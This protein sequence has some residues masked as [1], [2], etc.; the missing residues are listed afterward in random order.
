MVTVF[1]SDSNADSAPSRAR[2][3]AS[4]HI[5]VESAELATALT[6]A[7]VES[8]EGYDASGG[9]LRIDAAYDP[10]KRRLAIV[11]D[12]SV[13]GTFHVLESQRED[14]TSLI[15]ETVFITVEVRIARVHRQGANFLATH[16]ITASHNHPQTDLPLSVDTPYDEREQRLT[17]NL[18]GSG[19]A[20]GYLLALISID[21]AQSRLLAEAPGCAESVD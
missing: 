20:T 5:E 18:R 7:F 12:G 10:D 9:P 19:F 2:S 4:M 11:L 6:N 16:L 21:L 1:R 15:A 14:G 3:M 13:A 17:V 8:A